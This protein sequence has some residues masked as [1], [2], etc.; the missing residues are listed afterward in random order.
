MNRLA[1]LSLA[2][3]AAAPQDP[4]VYEVK[5]K[6]EKSLRRV[7]GVQDVSVG[8]SGDDLRV[9]IRC[10]QEAADAIQTLV[11]VK[12]EGY[13]LHFVIS[14][15]RPTVAENSNSRPTV[16]E[17]RK[18]TTTKDRPSDDEP[19]DVIREVTG[20]PKRKDIKNGV[21]CK[22]MV[23]WTNDPDKIRWLIDNGIPHW[24]SQEMGGLRGSDRGGVSCPD[25]GTHNGEFVAY[26]Y[27]K[28]R[29]T[30]PYGREILIKEVQKLTPSK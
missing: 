8:G 12:L 14:G 29:N 28:H 23:G 27:I 19:C 11:G 20:L 13:K 15:S 17:P 9:V 22:Q 30:C 25:H 5:Y 26:T 16:A 10:D 3:V 7:Q 2:L 4:S 1:L 24:Y 18:E 21:V 6:Y